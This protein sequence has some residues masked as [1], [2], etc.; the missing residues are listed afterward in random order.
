MQKIH[1]KGYMVEVSA[2]QLPNES[3]EA[4]VLVYLGG[5]T[6]RS[7]TARYADSYGNFATMD[8]AEARALELAQAWID[9]RSGK[10]G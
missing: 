9:V 5:P 2:R 10:S 4:Q 8:E 1:Y 3:W 7:K 6:E